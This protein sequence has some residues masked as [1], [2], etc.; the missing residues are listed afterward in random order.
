[1][2]QRY[3]P[4]RLSILVAAYLLISAGTLGAQTYYPSLPSYTT[5][6]GIYTDRRS[7]SGTSE[8]GLRYLKL[9]N[10][11]RESRNVDMA[12]YYLR[13]GYDLVR[14]R[15]S[16]YWEAVANEYQGLIYRD[17]GDNATAREYFRRAESIY[18]TVINPLRSESS[19]DAV[20]KIVSDVET[21]WRYFYPPASMQN[22]RWY[23]N[24]YY[25]NQYAASNYRAELVERER[26]QRA[27]MLLQGRL[28]ELET[29]LRYIEQPV[30]YGR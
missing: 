8:L 16:R 14:G 6:E 17:M 26:L 27:N 13:L 25:N 4:F 7:A 12:Q 21:G 2:I 3:L 23:S 9:A 28:S 11:Y 29:R 10:T 30:Y 18:R 1:M 22:Y 24:D 15:G 5:D 19:I 20:R